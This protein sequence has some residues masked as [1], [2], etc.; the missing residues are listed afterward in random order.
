M[1][2]VLGNMLNGG[3]INPDG[4]SLDLQFAADKTLT[5][6]R[7]PTPTFVRGSGATQVGATGLIEYAPEN[8]MLNSGNVSL[9][10]RL[11]VPVATS[12]TGGP[13]G[14]YY[15]LGVDAVNDFHI[16]RN[17]GVTPAA[18][19]SSMMWVLAKRGTARY[20]R[21]GGGAASTFDWD[22]L[23][24]SSI[25]TTHSAG[26]A[27]AVGD[28]WYWLPILRGQTLFIDLAPSSSSGTTFSYNETANVTVEVAA[29]QVSRSILLQNT[30]PTYIPT[31]T[32]AVFNA[33]F[34]HDP[35]TLA[36]KGLLIEEGRTNLLAR[37][38]DFADA[39]YFKTGASVSS[40][41]STNP[42]G[43]A[44][45]QQIT[46]DTTVGG[47]GIITPT[48]ASGTYTFSVFVKASGR[49][50][51]RFSLL[52]ID[53]WFN[54]S[55][56]VVGTIGAGHTPSIVSFGNGW[57]RVIVTF[58]S[59]AAASALLRL[60]TDNN[61][62]TY[63]GDGTSGILLWG[64]QVEAGSFPTSYI[65]TTTGTLARGAD[66]C[67]ITGGN[68]N[69]FYNQSEGTLFSTASTFSP[70]TNIRR[71]VFATDGTAANRAG[72]LF[73]NVGQPTT[74]VASSGGSLSALIASPVSSITAPVKIAG[75]YKVNDFAI[76]ANGST[77]TNDTSGLV[78][79][80][81]N[82]LNIGSQN[83][84]ELI[85]GHIAAIR[86]YKKRLPNA[87]LQSLTV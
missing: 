53:T 6:R 63:T 2:Y 80:G 45:S 21:I 22:T 65:P 50:W 87:K 73:N 9:M 69:N 55:S 3:G 68:F 79:V 64:A 33:R 44:T 27:V 35:V 60:A 15:T 39:A 37:S 71:I 82:R 84:T 83:D 86:Y 46:E 72:F 77:V 34:D 81:I 74:F 56:G 20:L 49:S 57:Y 19:A 26:D 76:S 36:C 23:T 66:V 16:Y 75:A 14:S 32:A 24:F 25:S 70:N 67:N 62:S 78:G 40:I 51:F 4:L 58:T 8:L 31:T 47:H 17:S 5:A 59:A 38:D 42:S 11:N 12:Q 7:G 30:A 61:I 28:G 43:G 41:S 54:I 29:I 1:Q 13:L 10:S 52:G 18:S 85:N 48:F